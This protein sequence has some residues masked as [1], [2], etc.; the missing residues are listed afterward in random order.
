MRKIKKWISLLLVLA[1]T[2]GMGINAGAASGDKPILALGA[3]LSAEQRTTVLGILGVSEADLANYDVIYVTNQE[4]HQY[5][6]AYLSSSVIGTR[7]LSSVLIRPADEG[8]GLNVTTYNISYCTID[9]YTNALLTAGLEDADVYVAAPSNISGTSA[10]IGAVKGYADMTGSSV[11]ETALETAVNELVVTG[12]I[13]D[14]LGDSETASDIVAYIKQQ[15][16]EQGVDSDA[17]IE[18]IIRNAMEEFDI[19]L[20]DEDVAKLVELMNKISKLD[21]DVNALAQ[22]ASQLYEKLKG[23]GLDLE[24]IDTEQVGNFITR[25]FDRIVE[26]I[27]SL[28]E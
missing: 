2:L 22:Q 8:A 18:T 6:D 7:A 3:D 1:M 21:I 19:S 5:L 25:F 15:I 20:S 28:L 23:M 4:E 27:N 11:D 10:L 9:M 16:I 13:G 24:N 26:L 17:D 14:V 12:E